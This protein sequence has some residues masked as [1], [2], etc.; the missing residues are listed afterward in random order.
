MAIL[1]SKICI[2][3]LRLDFNAILTTQFDFVMRFTLKNQ[4]NY[5]KNQSKND[6]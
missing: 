4:Q 5:R 6:I 3:A 2:G 1:C